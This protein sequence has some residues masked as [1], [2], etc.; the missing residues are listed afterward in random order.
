M[1]HIS[2]KTSNEHRNQK[3]VEYGD[4]YYLQ[5][6]RCCLHHLSKGMCTGPPVP[7]LPVKIDVKIGTLEQHQAGTLLCRMPKPGM[8]CG[9]R[10]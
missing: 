5:G 9:K 1:Q 3:F 6:S 10:H 4:Q 8:R 2:A 7:C